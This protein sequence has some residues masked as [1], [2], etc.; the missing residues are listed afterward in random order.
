MATPSKSPG[1]CL[2]AEHFV[3]PKAE[4]RAGTAR[5]TAG[6]AYPRCQSGL[7][8]VEFRLS[9]VRALANETINFTGGDV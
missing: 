7:P 5:R 8:G 1:R 6:P 9:V 4:H 3:K 2:T